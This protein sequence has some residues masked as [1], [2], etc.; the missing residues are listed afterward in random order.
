M[1][2][3][4]SKLPVVKNGVFGDDLMKGQE[5]GRG[6]VK[7]KIGPIEK[8]VPYTGFSM[9]DVELKLKGA[10]VENT[11]F[12]RRASEGSVQK[13]WCQKTR[14]GQEAYNV[15]K[16]VEANGKRKKPEDEEEGRGAIVVKKGRNIGERPKKSNNSTQ[17]EDNYGSGL[18]EVVVQPRRP[19]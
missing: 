6:P 2:K 7:T 18:A 11:E 16:K 9:A 19:Q 8:R 4:G 13:S 15:V 5:S 12:K 1:G 17:R 3:L 10:V 14:E